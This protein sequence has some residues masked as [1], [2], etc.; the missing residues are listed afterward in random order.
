MQKR[1][2]SLVVEG[3]MRSMRSMLLVVD[4]LYALYASIFRSI[5]YADM[6]RSIHYASMVRSKHVQCLS[7]WVC[8]GTGRKEVWGSVKRGLLASTWINNGPLSGLRW[9]TG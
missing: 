2:A 6:L 4:A 5:H 1:R 8:G 9:D 7:T 3:S